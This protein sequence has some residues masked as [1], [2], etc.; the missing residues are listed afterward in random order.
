MLNK[1]RNLVTSMLSCILHYNTFTLITLLTLLCHSTLVA[2]DIDAKGYVAEGIQ[3]VMILF[4]GKPFP[5]PTRNFTNYFHIS[6]FLDGRWRLEIEDFADRYSRS[7]DSKFGSPVGSTARTVLTYDG[8]DCYYVREERNPKGDSNDGAEFIPYPAYV[9][10]GSMPLVPNFPDD[11][12]GV[13]WIGFLGGGYLRAL[14]TTSIPLPWKSPR[15]SLLAYGFR[16]DYKADSAPPYT[17]REVSFYRDHS[18]DLGEAAE[19]D[20]PELDAPKDAAT[21]KDLKEQLQLRKT[22]FP[23]GFLIARHELRASTNFHGWDVPLEFVLN[24]YDPYRTNAPFFHTITVTNLTLMESAVSL[25]PILPY[26]ALVEDSRFRM[27][28]HQHT[29]NEI[30]YSLGPTNVWPETNDVVLAKQFRTISMA[31][32]RINYSIENL[33]KWLAITMFLGLIALVPYMFWKRNKPTEAQ[34]VGKDKLN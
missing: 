28:D 24:R 20:R 31:S 16:F 9:S 5:D 6:V 19:L 27:R 2:G 30:R 3:R 13:I 11:G 21:A 7:S 33:K 10:T 26:R 8:K 18:F 14:K 12:R 1:K 22:A 29:L 23:E 32:Y 25:Q 34:P 17:A 15:V 4:K